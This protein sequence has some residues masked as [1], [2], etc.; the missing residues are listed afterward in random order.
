M[1]FLLTRLYYNE[2]HPIVIID[3]EL[4][5]RLTDAQLAFVLGELGHLLLEH[6]NDVIKNET[7]VALSHE[8]SYET[9]KRA[10]VVGVV[11]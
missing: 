7:N 8:L 1:M 11:R 6:V 9:E 4:V 3:A 10:D 2:G 5:R